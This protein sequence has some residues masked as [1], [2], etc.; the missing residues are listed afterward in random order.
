MSPEGRHAAS[1]EEVL[2]SK[3]GQPTGRLAHLDQF[4]VEDE[5]VGNVPP[6]DGPR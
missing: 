2:D 3:K 4:G 1:R 5:R 6:L